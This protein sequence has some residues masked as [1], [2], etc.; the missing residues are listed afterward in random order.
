M[1]PGATHAQI[2]T[3]GD[4]EARLNSYVNASSFCAPPVVGNGFDFGNTGRGIVVGPNQANWDASATKSFVVGGLSEQGNI[5]FR[6]EFFNAFNTPQFSNPGT[7]TQTATF[8]KIT[9]TSVTPRLIQF[10]LKYRF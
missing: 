6:A 3:S 4:T 10:A 2:P 1:C 8:G 7:N 9:S 5:Q